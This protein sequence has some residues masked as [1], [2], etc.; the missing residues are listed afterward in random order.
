MHRKKRWRKQIMK[1]TR[2]NVWIVAIM[3]LAALAMMFT[4]QISTAYAVSGNIP[5]HYYTSDGAKAELHTDG[6]CT[7]YTT[8]DAQK[9]LVPKE[10][11]DKLTA[12]ETAISDLHFEADKQAAA[13]ITVKIGKVKNLK[14]RKA[15][16][17]L[18]KPNLNA[19]KGKA[20][21]A[22]TAQEVTGIDGFYVQYSTDKKFKKKVKTK[23]IENPAAKSA[24]IK[25]LKKGKTYYFRVC[26]YTRVTNSVS[27]DTATV[28]GKWSAKKKVKIT[29]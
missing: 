27:G 1:E 15:K 5:Y 3:V 7:E 25:H 19:S 2:S 6:E 20:A 24:T 18:G 13:A 8:V 26:T 29:R 9:T 16:V 28:K 4:I 22:V 14:G 12:A 11:M 21:P 10:A 23:T 17:P